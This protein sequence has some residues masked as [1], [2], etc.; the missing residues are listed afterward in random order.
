MTKKWNVDKQISFDRCF[1]IYNLQ[2]PILMTGGLTKAV[3]GNGD[4][5]NGKWLWN[6]MSN[7]P[8]SLAW[9]IRSP[10]S[11]K[12]L[13]SVAWLL[14]V[15]STYN[16]NLTEAIT[17]GV[18]LSQS[19]NAVFLGRKFCLWFLSLSLLRKTGTQAYWFYPSIISLFD[20]GLN[21]NFIIIHLLPEADFTLS[22]FSN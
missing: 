14:T 12:P 20:L 18:S 2:N 3:E 17:S 10:I 4:Q 15:Y 6:K 5:R 8:W 19:E 22:Y 1:P 13:W 7:I 16:F 21:N 9:L 11:L